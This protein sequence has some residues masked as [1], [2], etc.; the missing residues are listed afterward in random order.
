VDLS[1][2]A[3]FGREEAKR[4]KAKNVTFVSKGNELIEVDLG[5]IGERYVSGE[6]L[7]VLAEEVYL[8]HLT[9][10]K[11]LSD[12]GLVVPELELKEG[13][14][15]PEELQW[16]ERQFVETPSVETG[17][18]GPPDERPGRRPSAHLSRSAQ[19]ALILKGLPHDEIIRRYRDHEESLGSILYDLRM[20]NI[21]ATEYFL[22]EVL[23]LHGVVLRKRR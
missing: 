13:S 6:S 8:S 19:R 23:N 14:A 10:G 20:R 12:A 1:R 2:G 7:E 3:S 21:Y 16:P 17:P 9:L 22:K 15:D 11:Y 18:D 4:V 5:R